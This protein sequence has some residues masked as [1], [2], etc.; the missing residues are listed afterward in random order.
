MKN[1]AG[2]LVYSIVVLFAGCSFAMGWL[3]WFGFLDIE[4]KVDLLGMVI[5]SIVEIV[6][7]IIFLV[8]IIREGRR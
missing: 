5:S 1:V 7:I 4:V 8:L 3:A 2:Q 6:A